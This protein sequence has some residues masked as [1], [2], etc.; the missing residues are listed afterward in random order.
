MLPQFWS[1]PSSP[2]GLAYVDWAALQSS[3][4][5]KW[6]QHADRVRWNDVAPHVSL[7]LHSSWHAPAALPISS[8]NH[9]WHSPSVSSL[10]YQIGGSG[11]DEGGGGVAGGIG[12]EGGGGDGGGGDGGGGLG[13]GGDGG[14]GLGGGG[15]GEAEGGGSEG[16]AEGGGGESKTY[17]DSAV[18]QT[19]VPGSAS[20]K[21]KPLLTLMKGP[22]ATSFSGGDRFQPSWLSPPRPC[23]LEI[24]TPEPL[25]YMFTIVA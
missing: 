18:P 8:I 21:V 14:G 2:W 19:S 11:G 4:S 9:P 1:Q 5:L 3:T 25:L 24:A 13:G 22:P 10:T 15:D 20:S 12:G 6:S 16:G 7:R 23:L 17:C